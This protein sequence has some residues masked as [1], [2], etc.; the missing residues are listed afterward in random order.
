MRTQIQQTQTSNTRKRPFPPLPSER[1]EKL[2]AWGRASHSVAYVYRP[3]NS[4]QLADLFH[5]ARQTG[6][7]IG[8]RAGG[9]SYGDAPTNSEQLVVNLSRMNRIL[10]WNPENGRLRVEPGVTLQRVWEYT[11]ADGWWPPVC[12]G[13][14][15]TTMGGCAAM[16]TH[17]K[18]AWKVGHFGDHVYEFELMLPTGEQITCSREQNSD[19]FHAAIGGFGMLGCFTS[20]TLQLKHVYSGLLNVEAVIRPTL[21]ETIAYFDEHLHDSDYLVGW[22]DAFAKGNQFGRSELHRATLLAP[23]EDP[24]PRQSL[25]LS[26]QRLPDAI[27]GIIP[28]SIIWR[29]QRPFWNNLGMRFVNLGKFRAAKFRDGAKYQQ[30]HALFHF[31]LDHFDWDKPFGPGGLIQYQPFIPAA[32]AEAA[33]TEMFHLCHRRGLPNY[34]SVL[35]R[36]RPDD[37]L[38]S[39]G[40]DGYSM[41][42]DFRI[43]KGNRDRVIQLTR[44]LDGIVLA[45]NGRFY[46]AKDSTLRPA[47][48]QAYLG[49]ET[50]DQFR[51]LKARCDPDGLIQ[52]DLWRR[53]FQ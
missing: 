16:N 17:G 43:T 44:E 53:V 50:I 52:T 25:R 5:L 19:I 24:N 45:A 27:A 10:D 15:K 11:L 14:M 31:L 48:A 26:S 23:D 51:T 1:L 29:F 36:H 8:F 35:K 13:T 20:L 12:T 47:V 40:L 42:M 32:N 2:T 38:M 18:N 6:R 9:N 30:P 46:F 4:E 21:G 7:T 49:Q 22:L 34:L 37:F 39:Y 28:N 3:I 33:F 41:A